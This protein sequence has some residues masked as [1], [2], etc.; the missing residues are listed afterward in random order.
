MPNPIT[1]TQKKHDIIK[2]T[3]FSFARRPCLQP[4]TRVS[5]TPEYILKSRSGVDDPRSKKQKKNLSVKVSEP[6]H[7]S[8]QVMLRWSDGVTLHLGPSGMAINN[9][10]WEGDT[11]TD[12]MS[13]ANRSAHMPQVNATQGAEACYPGLPHD[14]HTSCSWWASPAGVR[15]QH[16]SV[17]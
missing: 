17:S 6:F 14:T 15:R 9:Y 12:I 11:P 13:N 4:F 16:A 10:N 5:T 1:S 3:V 2:S 8:G 7:Y